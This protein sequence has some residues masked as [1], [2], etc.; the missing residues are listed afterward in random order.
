M[1]SRSAV[2]EVSFTVSR[3][4][5]WCA[6]VEGLGLGASEEEARVWPPPLL[7]EGKGDSKRHSQSG[8]RVMV[9]VV[10]GVCCRKG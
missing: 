5:G 7:L 9:R 1:P 2:P 8:L 6:V 4:G 10:D 3:V